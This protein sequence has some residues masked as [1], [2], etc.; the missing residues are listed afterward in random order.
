MAAG[1]RRPSDL[2][3]LLDKADIVEVARQLGLQVDRKQTRPRRAICPFHNDTTPS[4]NLY[5]AGNG[6][7][8]HYHCFSCGAHGDLIGLVRG[9]KRIAF[10]DAVRWLADTLGVPPPMAHGVRIETRTATAALDA[11]IAQGKSRRFVAFCDARGFPADFLSGRGVGVVS[12]SELIERARGDRVFAETLIEAGIA[13]RAETTGSQNEFWRGG[14]RGFFGGERVVFRIDGT[15][16][17]VAGFAAR[18]LGDDTPKYL[19]TNGFPRKQTLYGAHDVLSDLRTAKESQETFRLHVVEGILDALRLTSFGLPANA[20]LGS[21]LTA[22]QAAVLG[23]ILARASEKYGALQIDLFLDPDEAGRR[24][25]FTSLAHLLK[26]QVDHGPFELR[27]IVPG[28]RMETKDDPDAWLRGMSSEAVRSAIEAAA[29]P[30]L[31]FLANYL[32]RRPAHASFGDSSVGEHAMAARRMV[33]TFDRTGLIFFLEQYEAPEGWAHFTDSLRVFLH[34]RPRTPAARELRDDAL[35]KAAPD[36]RSALL[37]ALSLSQ[38]TMLRREYAFDD[39]ALDR[40]SVAASAMYHVHAARLADDYRPS[41]PYLA[42][43]VPKGDGRMRFKCGPVAEDL[44]L[45]LYVMQELLRSHA[46]ADVI[47]A[48]RFDAGGKLLLTGERSLRDGEAREAVSFAYQVDMAIADRVATPSRAGLF[49]S[50]FACWRDFIE[51]ID[52]RV[53]RMPQEIVHVLRLDIS[54]YYDNV[55][56]VDVDD[57]LRAPLRQACERLEAFGEALVPLLCPRQTPTERADAILHFLLTHS[58][59]Y[60]Y[61]NPVNGEEERSAPDRGLPQGPDLSAYLAN[62]VLFDLDAMVAQEIESL[63]ALARRESGRED[64]CGGVYARYVDDM[65]LVCPDR[66]TARRLQG[67]IEAHLARMGLRLNRKNAPP[68]PMTRREARMWVTANRTG[69]GFSGPLSETLPIAFFDPLADAGDTPVDRKLALSLLHD[70]SLDDALIYVDKDGKGP[71]DGERRRN[72][73]ARLKAALS[74]PELRHNDRVSAY[75]RLWL[76]AAADASESAIASLFTELLI[77]IEDGQDKVFTF[78]KAHDCAIAI[79][80]AM[81][82]VMRI[83]LSLDEA[84]NRDRQVFVT[85]R[86]RLA[87]AQPHQLADAAART[88]LGQVGENKKTVCSEFLRRFDIAAQRLVIVNAAL[89]QVHDLDG[90]AVDTESIVMGIAPARFGSLWTTLRRRVRK[91]AAPKVDAPVE[92][93]DTARAVFAALHQ[94]IVGVEWWASQAN[95]EIPDVPLAAPEFGPVIG[96]AVSPLL[97]SANAIRSVWLNKEIS[98]PGDAHRDAA[99]ALVNM[100]SRCLAKVFEQWTNILSLLLNRRDDIKFNVIPQPPGL[101]ANAAL[102]IDAARSSKRKLTL[103]EFDS[104]GSGASEQLTEDAHTVVGIDWPAEPTSRVGKLRIYEGD[105]NGFQPMVEAGDQDYSPAAIADHYRGLF[106]SL[107]R[108]DAGRQLVPTAYSF[109]VRERSEEG[110]GTEYKAIT[111]TAPDVAINGHAFVRLGDGLQVVEVPERDAP[112]WRFGWAICDL[113]NHVAFV[114]EDQ[115]ADGDTN[116]SQRALIAQAIV[117]R[118]MRRLVGPDRFGAGTPSELGALPPRIARAL[119]ILDAHADVE[120]DPASAATIA[121]AAFAH[122]VMAHERIERPGQYWRPGGLAALLRRA[123]LR[124]AR[125]LR[126]SAENWSDAPTFGTVGLRRGVAA[127]LALGGRLSRNSSMLPEVVRDDLALLIA[128]CCLEGITAGLRRLALDLVAQGGAETLNGLDALMPDTGELQA[129][130]GPEIVLVESGEEALDRQTEALRDALAA[131]VVHGN[132]PS[133]PIT[134][135]GWAVLVGTLLNILPRVQTDAD[136]LRPTVPR[137]PRNDETS[138]QALTLLIEIAAVRAPRTGEDGREPQ[139]VFLPYVQIDAGDWTRARAALQ[140]LDAA[141]GLQVETIESEQAPLDRRTTDGGHPILI[142]PDRR[143]FALPTWCVSRVN[144]PGDSYMPEAWQRGTQRF[145]RF[146]TVSSETGALSVDVVSTQFAKT[147]FGDTAGRMV[148]PMTDVPP[149]PG[150]SEQQR[151][152]S[153]RDNESEGTPNHDQATHGS[154]VIQLGDVGLP[155]RPAEV[156]AAKPALPSSTRAGGR[157]DIHE[158]KK[159]IA[160]SWRERAPLPNMHRVAL[161]QWDVCDTYHFPEEHDGRQEGLIFREENA[162]GPAASLVPLR[163][164]TAGIW[165]QPKSKVISV[166]EFRRRRILGAALEA[167]RA[168]KVEGL[169][170]PEYSVRPETVNWLARRLL[171]SQYPQAIWAGTFRVPSGHTLLLDRRFPKYVYKKSS[172]EAATSGFPDFAAVIPTVYRAPADDRGFKQPSGPSTAVFIQDR[173]KRHPSVAADELILPLGQDWEPLFAGTFWGHMHLQS[174]TAELVC[175]EIFLHAS[176]GNIPGAIAAADRLQKLLG[177]RGHD[178]QIRKGISDEIEN[179]SR[180]T[181]FQEW[182]T[183]GKGRNRDLQR[184]ILIVPAMTSRSADYHIFGQNHHLA[185]G[186]ITVFVNAVC[187]GYA[188]GES[189]FIGLDAW[190]EMRIKDSPY[191]DVGPGIFHFQRG[192]FGPLGANE[193]AMVIADIDP[194]HSTDHQPRPHFQPRPLSLVA[195]LPLM[196]MTRHY[197]GA[198][199]SESGDYPVGDRVLRRE[200]VRFGEAAKTF[201]EA[202]VEAWPDM[203][204]TLKVLESFAD[205]PKWLAKRREARQK[206][207]HLYPSRAALPPVLADWIYVDDAW[208]TNDWA[209]LERFGDPAGWTDDDPWLDFPNRSGDDRP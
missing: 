65:V 206:R 171:E 52:R 26:L 137:G 13:H 23:Q 27:V 35:T 166:Q 60:S 174:F 189:C 175:S 34:G 167:C 1:H 83:E 209:T 177:I 180:Y 92:R 73:L 173:L 120:N 89:S 22:E 45:Q 76:I 67:Q 102:L 205:D 68:P 59:G 203:D 119:R 53:A 39:A 46:A 170:L 143:E 49:R 6:D 97:Q 130:I 148:I 165:T 162:F 202:V 54:G 103:V 207:S 14:L 31:I 81:E 193:A 158:I 201:E 160:E 19:Y 178:D 48:V 138:S 144:L 106:G 127:W 84:E 133:P 41:A 157:R 198:K 110:E 145:F 98:D 28:A 156:P 33:E 122:G 161:L 154:G 8:P 21:S 141:A 10:L 196:F 95:Q 93:N 100:A 108:V 128:G 75:R 5:Q 3:D 17:A 200:V 109:F 118:T 134:A 29:V 172:E 57:A 101:R 51:H 63:D 58:F 88:V 87:R 123:T 70:P 77:E 136:L 114:R 195:H 18:A 25:T 79:Y 64:A 113:F 4:L 159:Q 7:S 2:D 147:A 40:L 11:L 135:L 150:D 183:D 125:V 204:R 176:S 140:T 96:G 194:I 129:R 61:T 71:G 107:P 42:R 15:D 66:A 44:L 30:A 104:Q 69:F 99:A 168:F 56:R 50:Y 187:R 190:R 80:D 185:S 152:S 149:S 90:A 85:L 181:S 20:V 72:A 105:L 38:S 182:A 131:I 153:V 199:P 184:T 91:A 32:M 78:D 155:P 16:G 192:D 191:G 151:P 132:E 47:P 24:G 55:R 164:S 115:D 111:W 186:L 82:R 142:L 179:F 121:A 74:A 188:N 197:G 169:V 126:R 62:V 116:A 146:S 36:H 37:R 9:V 94:D 12:L 124:G 86:N 139:T 163:N 208:P 112:Y 117:R 43:H